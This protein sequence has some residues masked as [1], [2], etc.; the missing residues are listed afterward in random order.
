MRIPIQT[1]RSSLFTLYTLGFF[2]G[3]SISLMAYVTSIY[4]ERVWDTENVSIFYIVPPIGTLILLLYLHRLI[5]KFGRAASLSFLLITQM[6]FLVCLGGTGVSV[7]GTFLLMLYLLLSPIV[8]ATYDILL[9]AFSTDG[10]SGR[11]RGTYLTI[12]NTGFVIAPI[13]SMQLLDRYDFPSLFYALFVCYFIMFFLSLARFRN[14][15]HMKP[16]KQSIRN[17]A[18]A[19]LQ[20]KNIMFIYLLSV[21]LEI[22]FI[23]MVIYMPLYLRSVGL[24]LTEIGVVFSVMLLPYV[25]LEYP[26]GRIADKRFGEKEFIIAALAILAVSTML[27]PIVQTAS[28][29]VWMVILFTTRVG[30]A[31]L[32]VMRD[33]YFYKR[34]N[35]G[36]IS[37]IAFFRTAR[38]LGIVLGSAFSM[39]FLLLTDNNIATLFLLLAGICVLAFYP[40]LKLK[41]SAPVSSE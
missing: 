38:P 16:P 28:I 22:F 39:I 17:L 19:V 30:A 24:T 5:A 25:L 41:D 31:L 26:A 23:I 6:V 20:K 11:I 15:S 35:G 27:I 1:K 7:S 12:L 4:F 33:S 2:L 3:L 36:D 32:E 10:S 37:I 34:V 40:A 21:T 13:I 9:E 8:V 29:L 14:I 18:R